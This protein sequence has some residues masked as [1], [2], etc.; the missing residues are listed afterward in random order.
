MDADYQGPNPVDERELDVLDQMDVVSCGM[1][2]PTHKI[3]RRYIDQCI[4]CSQDARHSR[5]N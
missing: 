2:I 4:V 1:F 3:N 5:L